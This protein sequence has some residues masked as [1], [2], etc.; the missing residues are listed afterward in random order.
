VLKKIFGHMRPDS[1]YQERIGAYGIGFD[2]RGNIPVVIARLDNGQEGHFL[3]GGGIENGET[4]SDC[5]IREC[6]EEAGLSVIPKDLV[7]RGDYHQ[8]IEQTNTSFHKVGYFYYMEI[9]EV[10]AEPSEPDHHLI[11]LTIDEVREKLFLPHQIWATEQVYRLM[12]Q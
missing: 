5:I 2:S 1:V 7:C 4:H 11:W 8:F 3:L 10:I 12:R 9:G 6:L